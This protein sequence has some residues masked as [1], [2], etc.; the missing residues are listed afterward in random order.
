MIQIFTGKNKKESGMLILEWLEEK[1][2][3][4]VIKK[5][6]EMEHLQTF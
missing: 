6:I 4:N 5:Y 2:N 3:G 1:R